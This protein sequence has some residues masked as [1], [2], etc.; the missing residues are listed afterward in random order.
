MATRDYVVRMP[1]DVTVRS[2]CEDVECEGWRCGWESHIDEGAPLGRAQAAYIRQHSGRTFTEMRRED[3]V[4]VFRFPS[5]QRC[6]AEH[7]TR[8]ARL[9][10]RQGHMIREHATFDDIAEDYTEHAGRLAEQLQKG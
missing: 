5:G 4:T 7:R 1:R 2:A 8:P 9:L 3:G 6:F 10:V